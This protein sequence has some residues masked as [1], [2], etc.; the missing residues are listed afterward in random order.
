MSKVF[1]IAFKLGGELTSSFKSAFGGAEGM[2]KTLGVAAAALGGTAA[3]TAVAGQV[4]EMED[5]LAKLS[6]QTGVYGKEMEA[7]GDVAKNV[8]KTGH[9]ESF[10][11]VTEALMQVKNQMHNLDNGELE[12]VTGNAMMLANTFDGEVNE[13]T[14]AANNLMT[15]FGVDSEKAFDMMAKGAQEGLNFSNE[16][17]DNI[18]EYAPLWSDY[19][20]QAEE[21][22]GILKSG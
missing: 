4:M 5:S 17:F 19:G 6:A 18:A 11:D 9:G 12:R 13:V 22:F 10:D 8:F 14:R 1:E 15:N 16:M 3:L 20:F 7:L 21:M 2:M